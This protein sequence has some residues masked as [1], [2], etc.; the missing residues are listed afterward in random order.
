MTP[1]HDDLSPRGLSTRPV[2]GGHTGRAAATKA[3]GAAV[4]GVIVAVIAMLAWSWLVRTVIIPPWL[5]A[6]GS[7]LVVWVPLGVAL[8]VAARSAARS[9]GTA[10]VRRPFVR[11]IDLLWGVGVGLMLRGVA[12]GIEV[13]LLGR[14]P[15]GG[16]QLEIDPAMAWFTLLVAPVLL[17]P[18]IEEFFFRGLALGSL[19]DIGQADASGT[20]RTTAT[21]S[22]VL[23]TSLLFAALHTLESPSPLIA[24]VTALSTFAFGLAAALLVV[25]TGRIGGAVIAHIVY[26]GSLILLLLG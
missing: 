25:F 26:N 7:Y 18:V 9:G 5:Q 1:S 14:M 3:W 21:V 10:V 17:G 6:V 15:G 23:I 4:V 19:R 16:L 22:A 24:L 20:R 11:P 2:E 13:V 12:A 8:V